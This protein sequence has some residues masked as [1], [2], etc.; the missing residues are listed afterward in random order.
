M[1]CEYFLPGSIGSMKT[2]NPNLRD[3]CPCN[4]IVQKLRGVLVNGSGVCSVNIFF[5]G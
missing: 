2:P 5:Q 1:Q 4:E 3:I